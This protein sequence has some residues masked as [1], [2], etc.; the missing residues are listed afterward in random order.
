MDRTFT[1]KLCVAD[2]LVKTGVGILGSL[3][4]TCNDAAPTA[5]NLDVYDGTTSGGTK[6]FST[7]FTTTPFNPVVLNLDYSFSVGLFLDFTTT[8]DVNVTV[9]YQ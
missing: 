6:I 3:A 9:G 8:A 4:F 1:P 5:G 2:T 7:A